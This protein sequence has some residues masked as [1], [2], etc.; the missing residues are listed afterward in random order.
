MTEPRSR[1]ILFRRDFRRFTGGH[2]K[3]WDYF[4]HALH[5]ECIRP[6]IFLTPGSD[7]VPGN[8]WQGLHPPPLAE[9][10]PS[11]ADILFLAGLDWLEVPASTDRPVINLIQGLRHADPGDPRREFLA[12]PATRICV[13]DEVAL[14]IEATGLVN[15]PV[16]VIPNGIDVGAPPPERQVRDIQVLIAGAKNAA[17]AADLAG[18]LRAA[19]IGS[20][21]L[22]DIVP[23]QTFLGLLARAT[24]VVTLPRRREGFFL[25]ALEAMALGAVVVCPDCV[26]NRSF[27]RDGQ[28]ALV[29]AY[30]IE[31]IVASVRAALGLPRSETD[32]ILRSASSIATAHSLEAER[33]SFLRILE[34]I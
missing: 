12:R 3:V 25:P 28:T 18:R 19:G 17:V 24:V 5:A 29:P 20:E 9:W 1:T 26:G 7:R 23:R 10:R 34:R 21:C 6:E 32:R 8:P 16:H 14:A 22:C 15:G 27:C 33:A 30:E 4:R 2:L 13:S 11:E 31:P